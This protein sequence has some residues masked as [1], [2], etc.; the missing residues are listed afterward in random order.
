LCIFS[1]TNPSVPDIP[2]PIERKLHSK[3]LNIVGSSSICYF[4][5]NLPHSSGACP[6][7]R[8]EPCVVSWEHFLVTLFFDEDF[9]LHCAFSVF[10]PCH[11]IITLVLKTFIFA[12]QFWV[13][14][15]IYT[16]VSDDLHHSRCDF[17]LRSNFIQGTSSRMCHFIAYCGSTVN[18]YLSTTS[19]KCLEHTD[20]LELAI[21]LAV[22]SADTSSTRASL[23][24]SDYFRPS[25]RCS[26]YGHQLKRWH[27]PL[28]WGKTY[29]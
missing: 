2:A 5:I 18:I 16:H 11:P 14:L 25:R 13:R 8:Y 17:H 28:L 21:L 19:R 1:T 15:A 26:K 4:I 27:R 10:R 12:E 24:R 29:A 22:F 9:S 23:W 6:T 7:P 20:L 3:T